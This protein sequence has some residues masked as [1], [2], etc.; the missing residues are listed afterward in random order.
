[1]IFHY[2]CY[3]MLSLNCILSIFDITIFENRSAQL[4]SANA[5]SISLIIRFLPH[6]LLASS[7]A[8]GDTLRAKGWALAYCPNS[9]KWGPGGNTAEINEARKGTGHH[10]SQSRWP[11]VRI[12]YGTYL[13]IYSSFYFVCHIIC[14]SRH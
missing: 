11:C 9:S 4:T 6:L 3:A 12:V 1:M 7:I 5:C 8:F 13:Y 10:T 2:M 14:Y